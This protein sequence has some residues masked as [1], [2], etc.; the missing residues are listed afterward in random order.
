VKKIEI[1][2]VDSSQKAIEKVE[3]I[4]VDDNDQIVQSSR[5]EWEEE[6]TS[7]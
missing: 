4:S 7:T 5:K 3:D 6:L 1:E 2:K